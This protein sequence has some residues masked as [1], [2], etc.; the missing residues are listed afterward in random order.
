VSLARL[1]GAERS[2]LSGRTGRP[3][4][5][6]I[7]AKTSRVEESHPYASRKRTVGGLAQAA[8]PQ[9]QDWTRLAQAATPQRQDWTTLLVVACLQSLLSPQVV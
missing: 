3:W 6:A 9:R 2:H 5:R 8:T 1:G 7:R 4:R